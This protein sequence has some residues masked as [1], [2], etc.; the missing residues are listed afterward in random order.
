MSM[1]VLTPGER[2]D[3]PN[4][5]VVS[6]GLVTVTVAGLVTVTTCSLISNPLIKMTG[7]LSFLH[8]VNT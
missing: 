3:Q 4:D 5:S 2:G 8:L 6:G 7:S 1:G